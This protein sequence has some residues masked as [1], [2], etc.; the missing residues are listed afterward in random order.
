[1][2]GARAVGMHAHVF[3]SAEQAAEIVKAGIRV[4]DSE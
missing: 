1:V 2:E 4:V 3:E